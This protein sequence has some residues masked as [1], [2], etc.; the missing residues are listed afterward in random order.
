MTSEDA[1]PQWAR[2]INRVAGFCA[3]PRQ[4]FDAVAAAEDRDG[5]GELAVPRRGVA[6]DDRKIEFV[7]GGF[8]AGEKLLRILNVAVARQCDGGDGGGGEARH[9]GAV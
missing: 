5:H 4:W 8:D 9:R 3:V 6:A 2:H 1:A 7:R